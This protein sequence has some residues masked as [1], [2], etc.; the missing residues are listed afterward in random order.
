MKQDKAN[1]QTEPLIPEGKALKSGCTCKLFP[2]IVL[3]VSD[4]CSEEDTLSVINY[5]FII[6]LL[7]LTDTLH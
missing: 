4:V 1:T 3:L 5:I 7:C 2:G 6:L